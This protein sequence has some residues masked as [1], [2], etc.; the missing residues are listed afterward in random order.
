MKDKRLEISINDLEDKKPL[1]RLVVL[2]MVLVFLMAGFFYL[3]E[4][5]ICS[6]SGG[7]MF[8]NNCLDLNTI[9]YCQFEEQVYK[10]PEEYFI[11]VTY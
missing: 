10:V 8:S 9:N 2:G 4:Y 11:N 1:I 7:N 6:K 5:Y 3:G